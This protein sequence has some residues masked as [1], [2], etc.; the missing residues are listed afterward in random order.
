M[1]NT[2]RSTSFAGPVLLTTLCLL[3]A[4]GGCGSDDDSGNNS[5]NAASTTGSPEQ[6]GATCEVDSECYP[7][8]A[9]GELIGD[10]L[11]LTEVRGGYCT[12]T[13]NGDEDC[14]A[15][16]GECE[17]NLSQVCS[18]FQSTGQMMCFLSCERD[19]IPDNRDEQT[20][21]QQEASRDF[22]C[23]SSGGGSNNRKICVPGDCGVGAACAG[24]A[25]CSGDLACVGTFTGGY[26]TERGCSSNADCPGDSRCVRE[27]DDTYCLAPCQGESDC[28]FCRGD[29]LK[30]TCTNDA[31]FTDGD[32]SVSVCVPPR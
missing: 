1:R 18:P 25:D 4:A 6:A 19:D 27:G 12:H 16:E 17:T 5:S 7:H 2:L 14:C 20:Y 13:C 28:S 30:A 15:A 3:F 21:C 24:D 11:C 8:V 23:R 31:D 10:A 29:D 22:I 32:D 9:E 26:C